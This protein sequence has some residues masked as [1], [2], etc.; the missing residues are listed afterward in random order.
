MIELKTT[1]ELDT[2]R[3][4]GA[5]V[6]TVL[7]EVRRNATVGTSL[8]E[9]DAQARDL[10]SAHGAGSSFLDYHPAFAPTPYPAV[11]CTSVND[12]MLHG[13]PDRYRLRD[14]D[15]LSVDFGAYLDGWHGDSATTFVVGHTH[16]GDDVL[17]KTADDALAAG[18]AAAQPGNHLGDIAHAISAV[19]RGA[20][21]GMQADFAGHGVGR[22]M[23]EDPFVPNIVRGRRGFRLVPGLVIAIEP[24]LIT[25]GHDEYRVAPDGWSLT[26]DDGSRTAHVEHTVAITEDGPEILTRR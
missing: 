4:A 20:G 16:P 6:A 14:G 15:V 17:I 5:V 2:M 24:S 25:G 26:S 18:I 23:H 11:L 1:G 9:L 19:V 22:A 3:A 7:D 10:L 12:V 13:I 21:F 8:L